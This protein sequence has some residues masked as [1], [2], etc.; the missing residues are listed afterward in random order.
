MTLLGYLLVTAAIIGVWYAA[1][2]S[3]WKRRL[4]A[5][6]ACIVLLAF[7]ICLTREM[8][9]F[10]VAGVLLILASVVRGLPA[11][12]AFFAL[13][14]GSAV[15]LASI[16]VLVSN[17]FADPL[18]GRG[19]VEDRTN[20]KPS[21]EVLTAAEILE[22]PWSTEDLNADW[23][24]TKL[25]LDLSEVAY[26]TPVEA[27]ADFERQGFESETLSSGSM[28]G[29][30]LKA[31]DN[32]VVL[33]R[34][35]ESSAY[36]LL[37]DLLFIRKNVGNGSMHGG[38]RRG[39]DASMHEQV[40]KLLAKYQPTRVWITGHSLGGAMAVVCAH[41]LIE[42]GE[43]DIAGVM[44]FGQPMVISE[45]L[46]KTLEPKLQGRYAFFVNDMDPV[47]KF[48]EPYVHFGHMVRYRDG[49]IERE[50]REVLFGATG[51]GAGDLPKNELQIMDEAET[52]EEL[53]ELIESLQSQEATATSPPQGA[54][55]PGA[56]PQYQGFLPD[57]SDHY[58]ISYREMVEA[59]TKGAKE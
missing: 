28:N 50:D 44:T 21:E 30:V 56:P 20:W 36:D 15:L 19:R 58:L 9:Y 51:D 23:P 32:A 48:V 52:A 3:T 22:S 35:T 39:Y 4:L 49:T 38:F 43:Y 12:C 7:G 31:G 47:V 53:D 17:Q 8:P 1:S 42:D 54:G 45:G 57:A 18:D 16:A 26:R 25:M 11:R 29:Y 41:D 59:L 5:R 40:R 14:L 6:L 10:A 13:R 55:D 33:L 37:Q 24:A 27:R 46:R 34:G 2:L